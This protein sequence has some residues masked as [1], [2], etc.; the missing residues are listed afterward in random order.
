MRRRQRVYVSA[1]YS[2]V[3]STLALYTL[4]FVETVIPCYDHSH[5]Q[6]PTNAPEVPC[7][8]LIIYTDAKVMPRYANFVTD[9]NGVP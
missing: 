7:I 2:S 8:W 4:H 6:N 3:G 1:E 5:F 9:F